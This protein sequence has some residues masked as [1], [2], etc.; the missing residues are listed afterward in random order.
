MLGPEHREV[1]VSLNL[2]A[3]LYFEQGRYADAEPHQKR[4]LAIWEGVLGPEHPTIANYLNFLARLYADSGRY[5]EAEPL[6]KRALA[7]REKV[8]GPEHPNVAVS[9]NDLANVYLDEGRYAEA[10]P[11]HKRALAIDEKALGPAHPE[12]ATHL[13]NLGRLYFEQGRYAE[14]EPLRKRALAIW[15]KAFGPQRAEVAMGLKNLARLYAAQERYA[16]A[17]P[18]YKQALAIW[19]KVLGPEHPNVATALR[20]LAVLYADQG[21]YA[22]AEPLHKRALAIREK[23]LGPEHPNVADSL[24]YLARLYTVQGRY[25]EAEPLMDRATDIVEWKRG[26]PDMAIRAYQ[27]RAEL[28]WQAKRSGEAVADLRRAMELAEQLRTQSSGAEHERAEFFGQFSAIFE[29]MVAWQRE[30]GDVSEV[31][32][33]MERAHARSLLDDLRSAG[34]DL[35]VG[36]PAQQR[37]EMVRR[38]RELKTRVASLEVQREKA[39]EDQQ[40]RR[41]DAE[42]GE[43]REALYQFYRDQ[44]STSPVYRNLL[45]SG[46]TS[47]RLSLLERQLRAHG[48]LLLA[49]LLGEKGG[50]VLSIGLGKP[51]VTCLSIDAAA[52]KSLAIDAGPLTAKRLRA[53]LVKANGTGVVQQLSRSH[54]AAEVTERL[55]VLWKVLV[56]EADRDAISRGKAKRLV[57]VPDGPLGLLP[58]ETLVLQPGSNPQYLLDVDVPVVYVPSATVLYNLQMRVPTAGLTGTPPVLVVGDPVYPAET[59]LAVADSRRIAPLSAASRYRGAGGQLNRLPF[60]GVEADWVSQAF[61]KQGQAATK[62]V[63]ETATKANVRSG[64]GGRRV[65]HLACHG[66][67]DN[68]Y[69]NF[70]G[71]LALA[72]GK[73]ATNNPD[74]DGFLTLA[75]ICR[76]DLKG[77]E[78]AVL[79]ACDTNLGPQQRGEGVWALSRGF[80]VAGSRRVVASDWLVDDEAAATLIY[81]FCSAVA[82]AEKAGSQPDYAEALQKAKR[83]VRQQEKWQSPYCWATFVLIGPN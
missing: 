53:A 64:A 15:E 35:N 70:Y 4:A 34:A 36:R 25:A 63:R 55:S 61:E 24:I 47:V 12:I 20:N 44:R 16:E 80:L 19:E 73:D 74:D 79:S 59:Q 6:L 31:L 39:S 77:C 60:S 22:Q 50:Y 38:E 1:A 29:Q 58:F 65:V 7:I 17:E 62:L 48:G 21:R 68:A 18:L 75:D 30:L 5:A 45:A 11:L 49:Y 52:A 28:G 67:V 54:K 82:A 51:R 33:A 9:L 8:F 81:Y 57:V 66:C 83:S 27:L 3:R 41:L 32:S 23:A 76:L 78:L 26:S 10:E 13:T 71:A 42:L 46:G 2:L 37:E 72:P 14:A 56:P 43:A 40:Q 69:G